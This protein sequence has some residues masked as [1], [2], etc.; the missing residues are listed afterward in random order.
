MDLSVFY[1][2]VPLWE[3]ILRGT[4]VFW[5]L[6]LIFR[7]ILRRSMGDVSI[8][9]FLFVAIMADASQNAM[10]GDAKSVADGLALVSVLV[11]WNVLIDWLSYRSPW[12][13]RIMEAPPIVLVCNGILQTRAM[14]REF[15]TREDIMAKLRE[16]GMDNLADIK[17]MQLETDGQISVIPA[18]KT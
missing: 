14:R 3:I 10:S 4:I 16:S 13:R 17:Q 12:V 9:D 11:S 8:G 18:D 6:F 15:I 5:F 2:T 7:S 1:L